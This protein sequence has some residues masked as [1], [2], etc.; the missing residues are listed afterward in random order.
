MFTRS[1]GRLLDFNLKSERLD[2]NNILSNFVDA[3]IKCIHPQ[4]DEK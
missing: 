4:Y 1:R 2:N 3:Y